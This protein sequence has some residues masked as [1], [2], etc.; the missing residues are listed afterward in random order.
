M[1]SFTY[2]CESGINVKKKVAIYGGGL[3]AC[4]GNFQLWSTKNLFFPDILDIFYISSTCN[5]SRDN[6]TDSLC[7]QFSAIMS[8]YLWDDSTFKIC[9]FIGM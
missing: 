7:F 9:E 5:V 8:A 3:S 4:Y 2:R 6:P 1:Q